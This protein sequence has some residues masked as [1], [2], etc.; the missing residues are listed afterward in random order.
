VDVFSRR[1]LGWR[2]MTSKTTVLVTSVLEQALFTRRYAEF[3]FT[4]TGLVHHS[5]A[6]GQYT[7]IA[8]RPRRS[9]RPA[10][11]GRS[12]ASATPC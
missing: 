5:D 10:S 3:R 9:V 8:F 6:G 1:I 12:A 7:S 11:P 2:V 4:A